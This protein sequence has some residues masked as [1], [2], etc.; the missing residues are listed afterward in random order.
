MLRM[1]A[2]KTGKSSVREEP[3]QDTTQLK[4]P[5]IP[6]H[7]VIPKLHVIYHM[8]LKLKTQGFSLP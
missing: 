2:W 5:H 8:Q 7:P 6:A 3:Q 1:W 4:V